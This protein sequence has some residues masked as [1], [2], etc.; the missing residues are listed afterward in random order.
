MRAVTT[1]SDGGAILYDADVLRKIDAAFFE[2]QAWRAGGALVG[3]APGRGATWF[4][5]HA[6]G[7]LAL[8]HYRR[9]GMLGPWL[10]DR[11]L[12]LG[13]ARTR[14]FREWHLLAELWRRGLPVP[15]P[16]AA[17]VRRR[18]LRYTADLVTRRLPATESLAQRLQRRALPRA[19]W[20]AI[21]SCLRRFHAAGVWHADLNAHNILLDGERVFLLDFDRGRLRPPGGWGLDNLARL[22]RSLD[23][24]ARIQAGFHFANHDWAALLAGYDG[25]P[26]SGQSSS[27]AAR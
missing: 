16:V 7:E 2:P 23:K 12:W 6:T 17:R 21:G 26:S 18:G 20:D 4:V 5:R 9:G 25:A 8:R 13:L 14:A 22:R 24:L 15:Q 10:G 11:Y 3:E 19:G 27:S 1:A